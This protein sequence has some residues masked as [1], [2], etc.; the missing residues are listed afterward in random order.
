MVRFV[1]YLSIYTECGERGH[2]LRLGESEAFLNRE[3]ISNDFQSHTP[4]S[5]MTAEISINAIMVNLIIEISH[6]K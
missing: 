2:L 3:V 5:G 1:G 6:Q 4:G